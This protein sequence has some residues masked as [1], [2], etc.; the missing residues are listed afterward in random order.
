MAP[1][2]DGFTRVRPRLLAIAYRMLGS[3]AEAEEVVQDAWL[4]RHAQRDA[5][6]DN[7]EAWLVTATTRL[8]IDRLRAAKVQREHYPGLWL[9]EPVSTEGDPERIVE[10]AGELSIAFLVLLERLTPEARA[11]FLLREVFDLDYADMAAVLD[12]SEAACRQA[13]RR[14]KALLAEGPV[15]QSVAP[16]VHRRLLGG[17]A[18][19]AASGDLD[20]I[21]ALLADDAELV[22]D[23]GGKVRSFPRP[24]HGAQRIAQLF[25]ATKRR[26]GAGVELRAAE[27]N[28]EPALL[29]FVDGALESA[30]SVETDGRR[31]TRIRIQR[32]PDKLARLA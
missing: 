6:V 8:A 1:L 31:I 2:T 14:A 3:M 15:R 29:R 28:G 25:Y 16:D 11:A 30:L 20:R 19:A 32:N 23:G 9:P 10:R 13:V 18:E 12:K 5:P 4:R 17:F 24:L 26:L 22:S 7:D 21:K 27:L